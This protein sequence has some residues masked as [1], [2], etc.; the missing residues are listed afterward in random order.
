MYKKLGDR[1]VL[2]ISS[3]LFKFYLVAAQVRSA[4]FLVTI[5]VSRNLHKMGRSRAYRTS[6]SQ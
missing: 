3:E 1:L 5:Y 4:T 2:R 6:F